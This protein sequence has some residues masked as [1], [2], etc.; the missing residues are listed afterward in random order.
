MWTNREVRYDESRK[1]EW[2]NGCK[3]RGKWRHMLQVEAIISR[4]TA[5]NVITRGI[6]NNHAHTPCCDAHEWFYDRNMV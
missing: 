6:E 3:C 2:G 1:R 4:D 5:N